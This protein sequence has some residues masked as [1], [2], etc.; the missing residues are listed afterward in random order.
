[1]TSVKP[2][3]ITF[4][5]TKL[6]EFY[7][8]QIKRGKSADL[9]DSYAMAK[10]LDLELYYRLNREWPNIDKRYKKRIKELEN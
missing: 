9:I 7:L 1:M 3:I 5:N 6:I 8:L 10:I 2:K 4:T